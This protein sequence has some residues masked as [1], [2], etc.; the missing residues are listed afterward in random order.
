[1]GEFNMFWNIVSTVASIATLVLFI[2][3]ILGRIWSMNKIKQEIDEKLDREYNENF[4]IVDE[5]DVGENTEEK[6][7][8]TATHTLLSVR[9]Y[10][11]FYSGK[12]GTI[13]KGNLVCDCGSLRN[14]FTFQ[15]N[16]YFPEGEPSYLLE[17]Q[18]LDHTIGRLVFEENGKNGI[19]S[20]QL[21]KEHTVESWIYYFIK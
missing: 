4:L 1:M 12:K 2:F 19:V 18:S 11:C 16:T 3:Y 17:Y 14:G 8:L 7:Y 13:S 5:F 21:Y 9:I 6:V 10:E 15:F 20:E